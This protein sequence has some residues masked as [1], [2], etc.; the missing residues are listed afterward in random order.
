VHPRVAAQLSRLDR[1]LPLARVG[2]QMAQIAPSLLGAD[3]PRTYLILAQNNHE[4]RGTGGFISAA[5]TVRLDAGRISDLKLID[6]YAVD[7]FAQ[8]HPAPPRAL[9]EQMGTQLLTLRDSSWAPDFPESA[10]VARALFLQD[11]GGATDGAIALDLEAVRLLVAALEP[12]QVAGVDQPV[13]GDNVI[14]WMKR[15][16][17]APQEG[18]GTVQEAKTSD[19]WANRKNFMGDLMAATLAKVQGGGGLNPVALGRALLAMLEGRHL[20]VAVDDPAL[21][22]VLAG[23][24][25]D[26]ALRPPAESDFLAV[27]DSNVGFNKANAAVQQQIDYRVEPAG[28]GL[29][30]TL[31]LTYTH[32]APAGSEPIC[33]RT[34]RYGDSYDAL[35]QRCYWEYLRVYAPGGSELLAAEGINHAAT[36]PGERGTTLFTGDFALRPGDQQTVTLSYRLPASVPVKPYRLAVRKQAGTLA[37]PLQV[38]VGGCRRTTDLGVDRVFECMISEPEK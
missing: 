10:Q 1:L 16:W 21:A 5:G 13:T 38:E 18:G 19:W 37:L 14:E 8:P 28:D 33:D 4:L 17:Q 7:N 27:V 20:Q 3:G 15:A 24:G 12:L 23:Q 36:E 29:M 11:Q 9:A 32:T 26:G 30:A 31:T 35:I 34:P 2:L 25:W 22:R 6:S